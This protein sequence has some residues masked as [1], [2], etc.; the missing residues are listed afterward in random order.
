MDAQRRPAAAIARLEARQGISKIQ[1]GHVR[2]GVATV[3]ARNR[4][5]NASD[6]SGIL[7]WLA[8][9]LLFLQFIRFHQQRSAFHASVFARLGGLPESSRPRLHRFLPELGQRH[10]SESRLLRESKQPASRYVRSEN[11]GYH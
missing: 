8:A 5:S 6:Q 10:A 2:R 1:V 7:V 11:L 3:S 4:F 9:A